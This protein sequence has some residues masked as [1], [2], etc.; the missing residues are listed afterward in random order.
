[1]QPAF[2]AVVGPR[3]VVDAGLVQQRAVE[4][5]AVR[6]EA[7]PA[8]AQP[9]VVL[10]VRDPALFGAGGGLVVQQHGHAVVEHAVARR[11]Q[12]QAQVG[13]VEAD[14]EALVEPVHRVEG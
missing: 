7:G 9:G 11:A 2:A 1:M 3:R 14:R 10:G 6:E 13:V 4:R 12:A 5:I 8:L